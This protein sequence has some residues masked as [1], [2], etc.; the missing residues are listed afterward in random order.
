MPTPDA[1]HPPAG[2]A[3]T[4]GPGARPPIPLLERVGL[5]RPELRAWAMYEWAT[6][7]MWA[8]IVSTVFPIYFSQVAAAEF[9]ASTAT[10]LFALATTALQGIYRAAVYRYALTGSAG[11]GF[12]EVPFEEVVR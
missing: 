1:M 5:H 12:H 11:D 7:G 6:T 8:V 2:P 4:P 9:D 3:P 10:R